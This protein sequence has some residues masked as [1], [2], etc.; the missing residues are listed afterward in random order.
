MA[1]APLD[2]AMDPIERPPH[3]S[4]IRLQAIISILIIFVVAVV[5]KYGA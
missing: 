2:P 5:A 1:E 3:R 4:A